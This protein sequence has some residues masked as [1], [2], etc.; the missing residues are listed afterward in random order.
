MRHVCNKGR[1][2][3]RTKAEPDA[4]LW[5]KL[6]VIADRK[7]PAF[8][9]IMGM[10]RDRILEELTEDYLTRALDFRD[11][12]A[13]SAIFVRLK[14]T[15]LTKA[16]GDVLEDPLEAVTSEYQNIILAGAKASLSLEPAV[17]RDL[18]YLATS[19]TLTNP[20][21]VR[22]ATQHAAQLIKAVDRDTQRAVAD[23]IARGLDSRTAMAPRQTAKLIREVVGLHPKQAQ[24]VSRF[25]FNQH[26]MGVPKADAN[27][28]RLASKLHRQRAMTIARTE[29][30][31]ASNA[32]VKL[33]GDQIATL[34][35]MRA[36]D[37]KYVWIVTPDDRLCDEC[38][39]M[40]EL[41]DTNDVP[42]LHPNCRCALNRKV[43]SI[44]ELEQRIADLQPTL[45]GEAG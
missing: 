9:R 5:Q 34:P 23:I 40:G 6:H 43:A 12:T 36:D 31:R 22:A 19:F 27:I 2:R 13:T 4:P 15:R 26:A 16:A 42:P 32:G 33:L 28:A 3:F 21:A 45:G 8:V 41:D 20:L 18:P 24:Q 10:Y 29:T 7:V 44:E 30:I 14:T 25:A 17:L 11:A 1:F 38:E 39:A 37:I 35:F